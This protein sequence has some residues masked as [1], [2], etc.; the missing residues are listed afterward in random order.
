[1]KILVLGGTRFMG[2]H[3]IKEL[4]A[5]GHEVTLGNRGKTADSFGDSVK[6]ITIERTSPESL[7][8]ALH[9][10]YF[11]IIYDNIAYCSNDIKYLLD[12]AHCG[13]YIFTSS[14]SVYQNIAEAAEGDFDPLVYPLKWCGRQDFPYDEI[15]RQ[16]ECAL[17][18]AYP[19]QNAAAVRFPFIIGQDDYTKRLHFYVQHVAESLP[20]HAENI[21][22]PLSF[23]T[24]LQAGK[25]LAWLGQNN[26][27]GSIN[28]AAAGAVSIAEV[29]AYTEKIAGKQA[30]LSSNGA[31]APYN[32]TFAYRLHTRR[33][34][35]LGYTFEPLGDSIFKILDGYLFEI[36]KNS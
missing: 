27:C 11:D 18:Q 23:I 3:L 10:R 26:F 22:Q 30:I 24:S 12:A 16:A 35:A 19:L 33:A 8:D 17:F 7:Y 31:P 20:I 2:V 25:F 5:Q 34:A 29:I 13:R 21:G 6:R 32:G 36:R 15:K 1:M 14:G 9:G 28:A 4:L